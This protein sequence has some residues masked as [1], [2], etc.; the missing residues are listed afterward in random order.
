MGFFYFGN[1]FVKQLLDKCSNVFWKDVFESWHTVMNM[2]FDY[3]TK[4]K[5]TPVLYNSQIKLTKMCLFFFTEI[6]IEKE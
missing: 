2:H 6:G 1:L 5:I 3:N 4:I